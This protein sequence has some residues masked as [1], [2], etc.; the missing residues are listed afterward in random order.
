MNILRKWY[1][2]FNPKKEVELI[3]VDTA[4]NTEPNIK[5]KD[6]INYLNEN[7]NYYKKYGKERISKMIKI[8]RDELESNLLSEQE[9]ARKRGA[10]LA[11]R[12]MMGGYEAMPAEI[13]NLAMKGDDI[14]KGIININNFT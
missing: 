14:K 1:N 4:K 11:Y 2:R 12:T 10:I 3:N 6:R 13:D 8:H 7:Y 5:D 9:T